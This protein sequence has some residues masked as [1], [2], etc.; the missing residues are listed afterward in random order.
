MPHQNLCQDATTFEASY[1]AGT[2]YVGAEVEMYPGP[3]GNRGVFGAWDP[4]A[5]QGLGDQGELPGVERRAGHRRRRGVL[6]HHGRLVQGGR[7]AHRQA[8]LWQFKTGSG[9]IGQ[10]VSYRG[11][12]G[13]QY[14]AV[15]SGVGGWAGA[16]R[17]GDLDVR[18]GTGGEGLRQR[19]A[20]LPNTRAREGCC[21]SSRCPEA[22]LL[23]LLAACAP[24][25]AQDAA[26]RCASA[27]IPTTCRIRTRTAAASRTASPR[28]WPPTCRRCEY[29]WLPHRRGFVRKTMG[30]GLCDVI[31]GVPAGFERVLTTRP[32]YRSSLRLRRP[33]G[34]AAPRFTIRACARGA[35]ACS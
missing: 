13:K 1:I 25:C 34:E 26:R 12:D 14:I 9:I 31:I 32:Y 4:V 21:M 3:G 19:D 35:S 33:R 18:D 5:A 30:A 10:P 27:P 15:L 23:C 24:A 17:V 22:A 16:D 6:R 29:D 2:P 11:P 7:R 20:D 8:L 28:C